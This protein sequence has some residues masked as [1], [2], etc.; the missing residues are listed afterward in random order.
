MKLSAA[1]LSLFA[2]ASW[3]APTSSPRK[4][5]VMALRSASPIHF[6]T[7][8]ATKNQ[9]V[10]NLPGDKVD[11]QCADGET[12]TAATLYINDGELFLYGPDDQVQQFLVDRSGM[13]QGV[14][15]YFNRTE[16][17]LPGG[18]LELKGWA[19]DENDNLNFDGNS[20]LA[21]PSQTDSTWTVWLAL[22]IDRPGGNEGCLGFTARTLTS[23]DPV[24]CAYSSH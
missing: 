1:V 19:V 8:S 9:L 12:H 18:R 14:V 10:L 5:S 22:G 3:A 6:A 13:G 23:Q 15:Q 24:P 4:F 21:C 7:I 11:S 16:N 2:A 17:N 20:L